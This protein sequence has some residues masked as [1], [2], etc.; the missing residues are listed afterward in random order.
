[1]ARKSRKCQKL[2]KSVACSKNVTNSLRL[3]YVSVQMCV[4]MCIDINI[5]VDVDKDVYFGVF[6]FDLLNRQA[7]CCKV[8]RETS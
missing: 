8:Q 6:L 7:G 3:M 4:Y 2:G 5:G 1:M